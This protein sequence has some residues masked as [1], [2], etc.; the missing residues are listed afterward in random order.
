MVMDIV[1][2]TINEP[3]TAVRAFADKACVSRVILVGDRKTPPIE[4]T[5]RIRYVDTEEQR[6]LFPALSESLPYNHYCRKIIGYLLAAQAGGPYIYDT[7]DDNIPYEHWGLPEFDGFDAVVRSANDWINIYE[8]FTDRKVWPRGL[9]LDRILDTGQFEIEQAS[10]LQIALIQG[11]ADVEPDVDAVYRLVVGENVEFERNTRF[12]VGRFVYSPF[13]SQNTYWKSEFLPLM[14]LPVTTSFRF[15][16]ILRSYVAQRLVWEK[17]ALI[18]FCSPTV[19]QD[20]NPHDIMADFRDEIPM[21]QQCD[22]VISM[23]NSLELEGDLSADLLTVYQGLISMGVCQD[24]EM[25]TLRAW[26]DACGNLGRQH[27]RQSL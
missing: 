1:I 10:D 3:T 18:A 17:G 2:T 4:S 25:T 12:A 19:F 13:N 9:P 11:L 23:L 27:T 24:H 21:Y 5:E 15:T 8:L 20:R 7:D 14:Y 16:D 6:D 22:A 26:L